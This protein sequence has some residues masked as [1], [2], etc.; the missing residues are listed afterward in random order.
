L[1]LF[2]STNI[3]DLI[4]AIQSLG[5]KDWFDCIQLAAT[6]ASTIISAI[7]IRVAIRIPIQIAEKQNKIALFEKR[8][9]FYHALMRCVMLSNGFKNAEKPISNEY[10]NKFIVLLINSN[11]NAFENDC[12]FTITAESIKN[13]I[14][15][16]DTLKCGK[17]LF[18]FEVEAY[19]SPI[20]DELITFV[21]EKETISQ[22]N[23]QKY[24]DDIK[25][26]EKQLIP[27]VENI[28][29]LTQELR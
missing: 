14:M 12:E 17:F 16:N 24:L 11:P 22:E 5:Q 26:V 10:F 21:V 18:D 28:L 29:K 25:K 4:F 8:Y 6:V 1:N 20:C 7:A 13:I 3:K 15:V 2:N 23:I 27:L 9:E 19:I